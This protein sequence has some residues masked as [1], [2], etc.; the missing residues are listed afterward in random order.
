MSSNNKI[1]IE[2]TNKGYK[3]WE[4]LCMDNDFEDSRELIAETFT[5]EMAIQKSYDYE[6]KLLDEGLYIEY[7]IGFIGI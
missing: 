5:I 6:R 3:V 7:G 4:W 2:K 1:M